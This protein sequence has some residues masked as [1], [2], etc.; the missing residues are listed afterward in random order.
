MEITTVNLDN[1][2]YDKP[3]LIKQSIIL[4][5]FIVTFKTNKE[6]INC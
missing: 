1:Y 6:K 3:K 4:N 2:Y 5:I